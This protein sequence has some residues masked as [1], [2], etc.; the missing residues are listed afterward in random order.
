MKLKLSQIIK[1][2]KLI[3][4]NFVWVVFTLTTI[5]C[6]PDRGLQFKANIYYAS[7][8]IVWLAI[9]LLLYLIGHKTLIIGWNQG[10]GSF[11]TLLVDHIYTLDLA[12]LEMDNKQNKRSSSVYGLVF[13][14]L[15]LTSLPYF[16]SHVSI[17]NF[18]Y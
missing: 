12:V 13:V 7:I 14:N 16:N 10:R 18:F 4:I 6:A 9:Q 3:T 1:R 5:R 2:E 8:S 11:V 15:S 17:T